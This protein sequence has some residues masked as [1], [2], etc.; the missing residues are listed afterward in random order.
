MKKDSKWVRLGVY[1][2]VVVMVAM[3]IWYLYIACVVLWQ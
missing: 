3:A 1:G 2:A